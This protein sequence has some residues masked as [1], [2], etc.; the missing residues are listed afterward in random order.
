MSTLARFIA[1]VGVIASI[2]VLSFS[3]VPA[4]AQLIWSTVPSGHTDG[5][6]SVAFSPDGLLASGSWDGTVRLWDTS[7]GAEVA[8]LEGHTRLVRSVAFS[9]DGLL[10]SGSDDGTVRLWDT[11]AGAEVAVLEGYTRGV[12]SVAFSPDGLLAS[13]SW[14]RTVKLWDVSTV[15][16]VEG[17]ASQEAP[18]QDAVN[19]V[20]YPI[21]HT[22]LR[23][24][25]TR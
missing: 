22:W 16:G 11:S 10:A 3:P 20:H 19:L 21:P 17:I 1:S 6:T 5:V 7:T 18:P 4:N 9:P 15:V 13:G 24:F 12:E 8:V 25:N 23:L 2:L 14:D